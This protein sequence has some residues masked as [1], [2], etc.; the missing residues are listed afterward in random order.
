MS[1]LDRTLESIKLAVDWN[2]AYLEGNRVHFTHPSN[3]GSMVLDQNT[4]VVTVFDKAS[5]ASSEVDEGISWR[6]RHRYDASEPLDLRLLNAE[7]NALYNMK[8]LGNRI[9]SPFDVF[10]RMSE[11]TLG[12]AE[13]RYEEY[14]G[15]ET[16]EWSLFS[17]EATW[18]K[19]QE[20]LASLENS[21]EG[22]SESLLARNV[23]HSLTGRSQGRWFIVY[24]LYGKN[25][26][27]QEAF[28]REPTEEEMDDMDYMTNYLYVSCS[29]C[30]WHGSGMCWYLDLGD[31]MR[32]LHQLWLE[33]KELHPECEGHLH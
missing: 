22:S 18:Q 29:G 10:S 11:R 23:I 32:S 16:S 33:H 6:L 25:Q 26:G 3:Q 19:F 14:S 2:I 24:Q 15:R 9:S 4:G 12:I 21:T 7:S 28:L 8:R 27:F 5:P 31:R 17:E 20:T 1:A 13:C 30:E